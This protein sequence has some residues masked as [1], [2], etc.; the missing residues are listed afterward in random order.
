ML[1]EFLIRSYLALS[2]ASLHLFSAIKGNFG[3]DEDFATLKRESFDII[4]VLRTRSRFDCRIILAF[5]A[6]ESSSLRCFKKRE[7]Y[8]LFLILSS[9]RRY[10]RLQ[11]LK[12]SISSCSDA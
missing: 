1:Y 9:R 7:F 2:E 12:F 3:I 5:S 6:V 10:L 8:H 4:S 11:L